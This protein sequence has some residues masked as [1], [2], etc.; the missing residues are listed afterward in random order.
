MA[1]T[2]PTPFEKNNKLPK[3]DKALK[4]NR[5]AYFAGLQ[6]AIDYKPDSENPYKENTL[7]WIAWRAG[8][9]GK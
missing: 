2:K 7:A 5:K 1:R 9:L 4:S 8:W 6:A 3:Q